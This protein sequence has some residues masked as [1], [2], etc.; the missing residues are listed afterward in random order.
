MNSTGIVQEIID[1]EGDYYEKRFV[2]GDL[3]SSEE[4]SITLKYPTLFFESLSEDVR[5]K[6]RIRLMIDNTR[7]AQMVKC[8]CVNKIMTGHRSELDFEDFV[9]YAGDTTSGIKFNSTNKRLSIFF[10]AVFLITIL[11]NW[12]KSLLIKI[13]HGHFSTVDLHTLHL[14]SIKT[15]P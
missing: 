13:Q 14:Y 9:H 6:I 11:T 7:I 10:V 3:D 12:K 4:S 2:I 1:E 8:Y 15:A 5:K